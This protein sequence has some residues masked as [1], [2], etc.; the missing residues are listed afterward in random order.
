MD[1]IH[2][3]TITVSRTAPFT[4]GGRK[5]IAYDWQ[6]LYAEAQAATLDRDLAALA[7]LHAV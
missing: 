6:S 3:T 2:S 4:N 1:R 7:P 5:G